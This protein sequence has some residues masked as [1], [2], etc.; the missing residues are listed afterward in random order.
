MSEMSFS[1]Y[2]KTEDT[3]RNNALAEFAF[4]FLFFAVQVHAWHLQTGSY[5]VHMALGDLYTGI[6]EVGDSLAESLM[7]VSKQKLVTPTKSYTLVQGTS[8]VDEIVNAISSV[9]AIATEFFNATGDEAGIN[10]T[11]ADIVALLDKTIY[12]LTQLR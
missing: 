1:N 10:N 12:K 9:K 5:E 3:N 11:L 4:D 2:V 8:S 6:P 7:A